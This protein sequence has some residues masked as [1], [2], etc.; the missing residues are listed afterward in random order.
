[1]Y[2]DIRNNKIKTGVIVCIFLTMITLIV[3][4]ICHAFGYSESA[5]IIALFF[6][7]G[8]TVLTYYNCDKVVLASVRARQATE[9]EYAQLNHILDGLMVA[10]VWKI[11][12]D[13]MLLILCNLMHLQLVEIQNIR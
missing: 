3:Y 2:E 7:I 12:Q 11:D 9:E 1:M 8:S 5:L 6:S 10:S 13:C 4:Y